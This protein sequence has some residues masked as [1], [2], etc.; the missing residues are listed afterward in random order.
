[1]KLAEAKSANVRNSAGSKPVQ[2]VSGQW[3]TARMKKKPIQVLHFTLR[4]EFIELHNLLKVMGVADSG[5]GGKAL[6]AAG[7]VTVDG[8]QELRKTAKIRAGQLVKLDGVSICVHA[9]PP[10]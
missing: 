9:A 5:G 8:A 4:D 3:H 10:A 7:G 1:M 2:S 6:V